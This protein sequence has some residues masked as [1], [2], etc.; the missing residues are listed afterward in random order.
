MV[1]M[2][3][4]QWLARFTGTQPIRYSGLGRLGWVKPP[5]RQIMNATGIE[6]SLLLT[7]AS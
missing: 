1:G 7:R 6:S 3:L 5:W 2:Q 4:P